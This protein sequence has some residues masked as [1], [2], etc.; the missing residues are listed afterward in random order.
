MSLLANLFKR[1]STATDVQPP[2]LN[3]NDINMMQQHQLLSLIQQTDQSQTLK[4]QAISRLDFDEQLLLLIKNT[5]RKLKFAAIKRLAELLDDSSIMLESLNH[6]LDHSQCLDIVSYCKNPELLATVLNQFN[7]QQDLANLVIHAHAA[8]TRQAAAR[9]IDEELLLHDLQKSLK[10][11]DKATY[12]IIKD[13]L[14]VIRADA[15]AQQ[16]IVDKL[17]DTCEHLERLANTIDEQSLPERFDRYQTHWKTHRALLN[18]NSLDARYCAASDACN[19][20]LDTIL[21]ALANIETEKKAIGSAKQA[22]QQL[23]LHIDDLS[24]ELLLSPESNTIKTTEQALSLIEQQWQ[25]HHA[26]YSANKK[27][28][29]LFNQ[30]RQLLTSLIELTE[31]QGLFSGKIIA[32]EDADTPEVKTSTY[33]ALK[34]FVT[35]LN[36]LNHR[37]SEKL[38]AIL[39]AINEH[40]QTLSDKQSVE[41]DLIQHVTRLINNAKNAGEQGKLRQAYGIRETITRKLAHTQALPKR[42]SERLENLDEIIKTLQDYRTFATEPKKHDLIAAMIVLVEKSKHENTDPSNLANHIQ[43]LQ[44]D[45]KELVYGGKDTQPEL[46]EQFHALAQTAYGPCNIYFL[47]KSEERDKNLQQRKNL[48]IELENYLSHN[49]WQE[50]D[51]KSVETILRTAKKQWEKNFPIDRSANKAVEKQ[52]RTVSKRIQEHIDTA[53]KKGRQ[54]KQ[55]II[56]EAQALSELDS[57]EA[58]NSVK[59]LQQKWQQSGKTWHKTD[60]LLWQ[61]FRSACDAVFNKKKIEIEAFMAELDANLA[62]AQS[63]CSELEATAKNDDGNILSQSVTITELRHQYDAIDDFPKRSS[64]AIQQRFEKSLISI[65][66]TIQHA[67][68]QE[69]HKAWQHIFSMKSSINHLQCLKDS[70]G[71]A[72][73]IN[74]LLQTIN[75]QK[76]SVTQWPKG[77]KN[78]LENALLKTSINNNPNELS[79]LCIRLDILLD[80]ASPESDKDLRMQ[81]QVS[82]LKEHMTGVSSS[83]STSEQIHQINLEWIGSNAIA[84]EDYSILEQ[85]FINTQQ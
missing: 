54:E 17:E 65:E 50:A 15:K 31:E 47:A 41:H 82:H 83:A 29:Q 51:W 78:K 4:E 32:F 52:F 60:N 39:I 64:N 76:K 63:I 61:E 73:T 35:H 53:Y 55:D 42:V 19:T 22:Y 20:R 11:K 10:H 79:L 13:K 77:S 80:K 74:A 18:N 30:S 40:A 27:Q 26:I 16:A 1:Q 7:N 37:L 44:N 81:Y 9:L 75:D 28:S 67:Q 71:S 69:T 68:Q 25:N 8:N 72:D 43:K 48:V 14:D 84:H 45:W 6:Q 3:I 24:I 56:K 58:T 57:R 46:W 33:N 66:K 34:P 12:R 49:Q 62:R 2:A 23:N 5:E 38:Q 85:R 36:V 21:Q 59:P 70:H